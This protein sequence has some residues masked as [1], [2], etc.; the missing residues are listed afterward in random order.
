MRHCLELRLDDRAFVSCEGEG[1]A[2]GVAA[3]DHNPEVAIGGVLVVEADGIVAALGIASAADL[4]LLLLDTNEGISVL[5]VQDKSIAEQVGIHP[6]DVLLHI[7]GISLSTVEALDNLLINCSEDTL[8]FKLQ[9]GK[10]EVSVQI[11][12]PSIVY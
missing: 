3:L 6:E 11:T 9:R 5:G 2:C 8:S 7:N 10:N 4:G 1:G 12:L